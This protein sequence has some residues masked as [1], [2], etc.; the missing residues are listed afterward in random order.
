MMQKIYQDILVAKAQDKKLLAILLDPDKIEMDNLT[1]LF[2][3]IKS[4]PATH[5]FVGGS[6]VKSNKIDELVLF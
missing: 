3:K 2:E 4:S 1:L 6:I 5:I